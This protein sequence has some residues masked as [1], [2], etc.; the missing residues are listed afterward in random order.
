MTAARID[1][2]AELPPGLPAAQPVDCSGSLSALPG[3]AAS[4]RVDGGLERVCGGVGQ[5]VQVAGEVYLPLRVGP[6]KRVGRDLFDQ[7]HEVI[8]LV[9]VAPLQVLGGTDEQAQV[10]DTDPLAPG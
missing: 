10:R 9:V 4:R 8:H 7:A 6:G 3:G 1:Q 5:E 2:P